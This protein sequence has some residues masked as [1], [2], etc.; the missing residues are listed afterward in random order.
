MAS[1][2]IGVG[3]T[4]KVRRPEI[5]K[6][7]NAS[8]GGVDKVD[9]LIGLYRI[10][11]RSRKWTLRL[12][13]HAIDMAICNS[14]LEYRKDAEKLN[15]KNIYDLLYFKL[16][17]GNSLINCGKPSAERKRG[18]PSLQDLEEN[19]SIEKRAKV[20]VR[21]STNVR[22]DTVDHLPIH[23]GHKEAGRYLSALNTS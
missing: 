21:P 8:M 4:D 2:F 17:I 9:F 6:K 16:E 15:I 19:A 1:N 13:F 18:R 3:N 20:E 22:L 10:F 5:I 7:Y 14:W 11:I 23:N 12:I